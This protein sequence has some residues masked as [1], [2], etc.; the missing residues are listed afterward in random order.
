MEYRTLIGYELNSFYSGPLKTL[1]APRPNE[2][3]IRPCLMSKLLMD[4]CQN[5]VFSLNFLCTNKC[6]TT[7]SMGKYGEIIP[8]RTEKVQCFK[9]NFPSKLKLPVGVYANDLHMRLQEMLT[10]VE[11]LTIN[12]KDL[13]RLHSNEVS[14]CSKQ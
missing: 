11:R 13:L 4:I 3:L 9:K 5:G 7:F 14:V 2:S 8:I 1:T 6:I 10:T 12:A